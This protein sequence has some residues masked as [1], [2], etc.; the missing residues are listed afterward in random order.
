MKLTPLLLLS[1]LLPLC[2]LSGLQA[3]EAAKWYRGNTHTHTLWSDG[4]QLPELAA[5]WYESH[6]YDFLVL[7]DHN[8]LSRGDKWADITK[9]EMQHKVLDQVRQ[10]FGE[11]AVTAKEENG[12]VLVKLKTLEEI[13][14]MLCKPGDFL[15]IEGDEITGKHGHRPAHANAINIDRCILPAKGETMAEQLAAY[16]TEVKEHGH[17]PLLCRAKLGLFG[18]VKNPG[19]REQGPLDLHGSES[20][21]GK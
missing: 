1:S 9:I 5:G 3:D 8:A 10:R 2:G 7:S 19:L 17:L 12:K 13:R 6:G 15:M 20:R 18:A 14:E 16:A 4:N 11:K 21:P